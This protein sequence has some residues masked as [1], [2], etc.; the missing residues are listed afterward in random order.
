MKQNTKI[1]LVLRIIQ[2][3]IAILKFRVATKTMLKSHKGL[4]YHLFNE[5]RVFEALGGV[6]DQTWPRTC[7]DITHKWQYW[8][9]YSGSI[10]YPVPVPTKPRALLPKH[11]AQFKYSNTPNLYI[12]AYG[13]LR[14]ELL[15]YTAQLIR[16]KLKELDNGN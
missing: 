7:R 2:V 11:E 12:G 6:I 5:S 3:R 16:D 8:E 15:D 4:C 10:A 9:Y 1:K 14:M 13:R